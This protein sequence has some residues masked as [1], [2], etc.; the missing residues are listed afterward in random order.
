MTFA[1][2]IEYAFVHG[3]GVTSAEVQQTTR[4]QERL[5]QQLSLYETYPEGDPLGY[6]LRKGYYGAGQFMQF[7]LRRKAKK[8]IP[9]LPVHETKQTLSERALLWELGH[10]LIEAA[11]RRL[12]S[13]LLLEDD[14]G[15]WFEMGL[16]EQHSLLQ[17]A[18]HRIYELEEDLPAD[19]IIRA[20]QVLPEQFSLSDERPQWPNCLGM[21][22]ILI[23][24]GHYV[25][26]P[27]LLTSTVQESYNLYWPSERNVCR[28]IL[29]DLRRRELPGP[30]PFT[31]HVK[32]HLAA[33][34]RMQP[35][36]QL[37]HH[38]VVFQVQGGAWMFCDIGDL[39]GL[40]ENHWRVCG[41]DQLLRLYEPVLPGLVV[42]SHDEGELRSIYAGARRKVRQ[43]L[44]AS[45]Q[46]LRDVHQY[47]PDG[48]KDMGEFIGFCCRYDPLRKLYEASRSQ[49]DNPPT[50][51]QTLANSVTLANHFPRQFCQVMRE[52]E[53]EGQP[54]IEC[55]ATN[56]R[57]RQVCV[58]RVA[59]EFHRF[60][61]E[62][63]LRDAEVLRTSSFHRLPP[64]LEFAL[65]EI[66]TA[67]F[68]LNHLRRWARDFLHIPG[69]SLQRHSNSQLLWMQNACRIYRRTPEQRFILEQGAAYV[70]SLDPFIHPAARY[71]LRRLN[72]RKERGKRSCQDTND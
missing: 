51:I 33:A 2:L 42:T 5:S 27:V 52:M 70:R 62:V 59:T 20:H 13:D 38:G 61:R 46:F 44:E 50:A 11:Q 36:R 63:Y 26:A 30:E 4:F 24:L 7:R 60:S 47:F 15:A 68:V 53:L 55:F 10:H 1:D 28:T 65:P 45:R 14:E 35:G 37:L 43:D 9:A 40:A 71:Q 69:E 34:N 17:T 6:A 29:K 16:T 64:I 66:Q 39:G 19:K 54:L 23:A 72:D 48:P 3:C 49:Q 32:E 31:T 12:P 18:S 8:I 56:E 21:A 22:L 58:A 25:G 41:V 67:L 57:F